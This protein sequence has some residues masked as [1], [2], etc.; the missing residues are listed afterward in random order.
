MANSEVENVSMGTFTGHY[1][2]FLIV[3]KKL[4]ICKL[5]NENPYSVMNNSCIYK[6][7]S[8]GRINQ[9]GVY[10]LFYSVPFFSDLNP[11]EQFWYQTEEQTEKEE[12]FSRENFHIKNKRSC[13]VSTV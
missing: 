12:A 8:I 13:N 7:P 5:Y 1:K 11:V 4:L 2:Q 10:R 3:L 6:K 9:A